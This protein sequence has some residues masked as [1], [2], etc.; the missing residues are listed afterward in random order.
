MTTRNV[1]IRDKGPSTKKQEEGV[2]AAGWRARSWPAGLKDPRI[3]RV[4]RALGGKDRHSKVSTVR[5]LRDRRVRLSVQTAIQL[6]DLQDRLGLNQ[7]SKV[8]DWLLD[9]AQHEIDKLPPLQ[10]P[11]GSCF[12]TSLPTMEMEAPSQLVPLPIRPSSHH[13]PMAASHDLDH[14]EDNRGGS[15][16]LLPGS[17]RDHQAL[18]LPRDHG[19]HGLLIKRTQQDPHLHDVNL[20]RLNFFSMPGSAGGTNPYASYCFLEASH[21]GGGYP[22][23]QAEDEVTHGYRPGAATTPHPSLSLSHGSQ[24]LLCSSGATAP[25]QMFSTY[26]YDPKLQVGSGT[27]FQMGSSAASQNP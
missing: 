25:P 5:G 26:D 1:S 16:A 24:L 11:P 13:H 4:S 9:A 18:P 6:Y 14:L 8:V 12:P 27:A 10:I 3:V 19:K 20:H 21:L 15:L 23:P 2:E 17:A 22:I 7:P